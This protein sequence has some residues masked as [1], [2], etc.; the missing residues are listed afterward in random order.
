MALILKKQSYDGIEVSYHHILIL[1]KFVNKQN[2]ISVRSFV[3]KAAREQAERGI[4]VYNQVETFY[5]DYDE[6]MTVKQA[7]EYLK[8]LDAFKGAEDDNEE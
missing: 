2:G 3:D 7:Y 1:D 4:P 8:T 6:T 5:T